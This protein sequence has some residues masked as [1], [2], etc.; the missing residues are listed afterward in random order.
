L[1]VPIVGLSVVASE[2]TRAVTVILTG[3]PGTL[4]RN[5]FGSS[6]ARATMYL[7]GWPPKDVTLKMGLSA[8]TSST[9][10]SPSMASTVTVQELPIPGADVTELMTGASSTA[11]M[12][13]VTVAASP[14]VPSLDEY[15]KV[16]VPK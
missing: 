16:S 13:T 12:L 14:R 2:P 11:A 6:S 15:W 9:T 1:T 7:P 3:C 8:W 5:E 10:P 4:C